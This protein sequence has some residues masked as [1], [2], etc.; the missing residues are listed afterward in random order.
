LNEVSKLL[1]NNKK[2]NVIL[3]AEKISK[4][5]TLPLSIVIAHISTLSLSYKDIFTEWKKAND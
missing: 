2:E 4:R 1:E 3:Y 5:L